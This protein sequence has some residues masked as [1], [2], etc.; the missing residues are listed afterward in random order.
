[1]GSRRSWVVCVALALA[2]S[3]SDEGGHDGG[4]PSAGAGGLSSSGSGSS[5]SGSNVGGTGGM[6]GVT[7][8]SA[9][10]GGSTSGMDDADAALAPTDAGS[11][12]SG[13]CFAAGERPPTGGAS[14]FAMPNL[15]QERATYRAFGWTW[16]ESAEPDHA[17]EP[18]YVVEDPDIHGDTEGDDLWNY[19][20]MWQRTGQ[21]GYLDRAEAWARY[22]KEDYR[23]CVGSEATSFCYDRD[24]YG[25]DHL[26]GYGLIAWHVA[27]QDDEALAEAV[28]LG[29]IVEGLWADDS[30]F[31][32]LPSGACTWY[33]VR[34]VGRHLLFATRLAEVTG[35]ARWDAL[36]DRM[37][38]RLLASAD[39]DDE[40]G[41]YF[42]G[43]F[44]TDEALGMGAYAAG[45]RIQ[46]P[47]QIGVLSEAFDHVY[48]VTGDEEVRR[49]M[50]RMA[51]FVAERGLDP[52]YQYTA[53]LFGIVDGETWH[54]Y[55]SEQ[56]TEEPVTFWDPVYT[57]S[58]VNVLMRGY[59]YSCDETLRASAQL[60]FQRG[61]GGL[62]GQP[63]ERAVPDGEVH[64]F[65]DSVYSTANGLFYLDYNKGELQYTY[66]LF[67]GSEP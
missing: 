63:T 59:R 43:D 52:T 26:A 3:S 41:M 20:M 33:G 60:F 2:A 1:M 21:E 28:R 5:G 54:S 6:G 46:S 47:F 65:V 44:G 4:A 67:E 48:R 22:F 13:G 35:D 11:A 27:M 31:G 64:H 40:R 49:R 45:A 18:D 24:A 39:W 8:G 58:L 16:A 30:P 38:E 15:E 34:Q 14:G 61:N 56:P 42:Q 50:V 36:R 7:S 10:R 9:G 57:T 53:S 29:E 17:A 19:L 23:S 37:L 55:A 25:A 51:E 62:Y 66:L 32:C 12:P